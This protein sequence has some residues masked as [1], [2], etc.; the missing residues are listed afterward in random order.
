MPCPHEAPDEAYIE[1]NKKREPEGER[2]RAELIEFLERNKIG[3]IYLDT[4]KLTVDVQSAKLP[5]KIKEVLSK[6]GSI[7]VVDDSPDEGACPHVG[8]A[9]IHSDSYHNG[10]PCTWCGA[11]EWTPPERPEGWDDNI[12]PAH[13]LSARQILE[14]AGFG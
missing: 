6:C 10:G 2:I 7:Y 3:S 11:K 5:P 14:A 1:K 9:G 4:D 12:V 13:D 8:S